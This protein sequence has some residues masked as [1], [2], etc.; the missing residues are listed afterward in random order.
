MTGAA[1]RR[2]DTGS[3]AVE[4]AFIMPLLLLMLA[5]LYG[6]GRVA[7][8]NGALEAGTRDGARAASQARSA[9]EARE[10]AERAVRSSLGAGADDCAGGG[11]TVVLRGGVF[12][13][14]FPVTVKASCTYRLHDLGLPGVPGSANVSSTFTSPVDPNRGAR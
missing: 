7:Q 13:P 6:Y 1:R 5:L 10:V 9:D 14:G 11:P 8:V 2:P 4:L 3:I 12:Q